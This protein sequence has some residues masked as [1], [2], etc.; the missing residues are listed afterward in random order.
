MIM[1]FKMQLNGRD[2]DINHIESQNGALQIH[3]SNQQKLAAEIERLLDTIHVDEGSIYTLKHASLESR[4]G[5][6]ELERAAGELYKSIVQ[7]TSTTDESVSAATERLDEYR[8]LSERF[9]KRICDHINLT[10]T[11]ETASYL[12][13]PARQNALSPSRHPGPSLQNHAHLE[14]LLGRYCG[15]VLY[16]KETSPNYF[17][18]LCASYYA[19]VSE[20]WKREM[21][22][23]LAGWKRR[24]K[25][26]QGDDYGWEVGDSNNANADGSKNPYEGKGSGELGAFGRAATIRR[27]VKGD[28]SKSSKVQ[29]DGDLT[30]AEVFQ[31]VLDSLTPLIQGEQTFIAD[32]LQINDSNVTFAD[33][34]DMEPYFRRR[35]AQLFGFGTAAHGSGPM[36]EM[37]GALELIFGFLA[38]EGD[39]LVDYAVH[40]D[41]SQIT[42]ILAL[43]DRA[44][45]DAE[46]VGSDFIVR[47]LTRMHTRLST[48]LDKIEDEQHGEGGNAAAGAGSGAA[49]GTQGKAA[50]EK[51]KKRVANLLRKHR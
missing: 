33:Y 16:L 23:F 22:T 2:E 28:K 13:D 10:I 9:C 17:S 38:L 35:A 32:F 51:K 19:S 12:S 24:I 29:D 14:E 11:A 47:T 41:K 15:L 8:A 25:R 50:G 44:I 3:T 5:I 31:R 27:V 1:R 6:E 40:M 48:V 39:A 34:A 20:C 49:A 26:G 4:G 45:G 42:P 36:R 30:A 43:L 37:K 21:V 46:E 7:A 18:R